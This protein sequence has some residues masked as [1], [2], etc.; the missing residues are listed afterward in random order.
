[1]EEIYFY[2]YGIFKKHD[3]YCY[4]STSR[5]WKNEK[6]CGNKML[7]G[8]IVFTKFLVFLIFTSVD[9]TVYQHMKNVLH[10]FYNVAQKYKITS[11]D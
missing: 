10:F 8:Q 1:M 2:L 3:I 4:I 6:L 5:N 11:T 7:V 9:V